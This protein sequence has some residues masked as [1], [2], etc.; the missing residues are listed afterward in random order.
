VLIDACAEINRLSSR[1]ALV[2]LAAFIRVRMAAAANV[3]GLD[4]RGARLGLSTLIS[5]IEDFITQNSEGGRRGQALAAAAFDLAFPYVRTGRVNDPSRRHPGD[6]QIMDGPWVVPA[7]EVRQKHVAE[8]E[9]LQFAASLRESKVA[10]GVIWGTLPRAFVNAR[11]RNIHRRGAYSSICALLAGRRCVEA[12]RT[13]RA[14][15]TLV[16]H[17]DLG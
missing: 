2:A 8:I 5:G 3:T 14:V 7:A 13:C 6:V 15:T 11:R 9:V 10:N 16:G 17:G 12:A 4:L 1:R